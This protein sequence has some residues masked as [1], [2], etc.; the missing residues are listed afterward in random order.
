MK[1]DE[2]QKLK[3]IAEKVLANAKLSQTE[4]FGSVI[5]I[6]M[7]ISIIL[8]AVRV[9]QECNKSKASSLAKEDKYS[10]YGQ[11]I[12]LFSSRR[13]W[14]TRMRLKKIIRKELNKEDYNKYSLV[15]VE[16]IL[17]TGE[18]LKEDEIITLVEAAHV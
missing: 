17:A 13:G 14:F 1:N 3:L 4:N 12:K 16:A 2:S 9:L 5:A 6:L 11:E 10:L 18:S 7:I 15:L 8:T